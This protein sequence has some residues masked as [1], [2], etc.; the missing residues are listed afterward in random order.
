MADVFLVEVTHP[1]VPQHRVMVEASGPVT[2]KRI[3]AE[4]V[5]KVSKLDAGEALKLHD[6]GV[7]LLREPSN[8]ANGEA[9]ES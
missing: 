9:G 1:K 8:G 7:Q 3:Y 4:Y 2:A 5:A 6:D